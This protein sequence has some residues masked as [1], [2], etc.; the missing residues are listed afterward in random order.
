MKKNIY[1]SLFLLVSLSAQADDYFKHGGIRYKIESFIDQELR[2]TYP[3]E[4]D[5]STTDLV[6]PATIK[7]KQGQVWTV[8]AI[9][10]GAFTKYSGNM[11]YKNLRSVSIP[12]T[13]KTIHPHAFEKCKLQ[14]MTLDC[15]ICPITK[16][17]GIGNYVGW[18]DLVLTI[19]LGPSATIE[20]CKGIGYESNGEDYVAKVTLNPSN[21]NLVM[22]D[23]A[24]YNKDKTELLYIQRDKTSA[25]IMPPT[26]KKV[27]KGVFS[28]LKISRVVLSNS[29]NKIDESMFYE[30]KNLESVTI[31]N[32]ITTIGP[33]A[34]S[35]CI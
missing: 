23:G 19:N 9:G 34:F 11:G 12:K 17:L 27:A 8:T 30:C 18:E 14:E 6:I 15:P 20:T 24:L 32:S 31:P 33:F 21:K 25:Y 26:V 1:L 3:D 13:I 4:P 35:H 2:V 5:F 29:L 10:D 7:T 28:R 22:V 16:D